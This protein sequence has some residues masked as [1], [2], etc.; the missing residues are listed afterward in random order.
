MSV[1][2]KWN[3][4]MD[5]PMGTQKF[6]WD[7]QPSG[8]G[9]TGTMNGSAGSAELTDIAVDGSNVICRSRVT[10]PMGPINLTFEGAANGDQISGKC[11]TMFG[12]SKFAGTRM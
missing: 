4:T 5:T 9:W 10:T 11:K 12:D 1:A 7:L 3:I 8:A 2:G 6:T